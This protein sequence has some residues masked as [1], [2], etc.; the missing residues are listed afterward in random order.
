MKNNK[1]NG[2]VKNVLSYFSKSENVK[3][4]F[5][6]DDE[7]K[8]GKID[9]ED[10]KLKI[11][12]NTTNIA[13]AG[14][15]ITDEQYKTL[16]SK[17]NA[18]TSFD[19]SHSTLV[20]I[21]KLKELSYST[22]DKPAISLTFEGKDGKIKVYDESFDLTISSEY[23]GSDFEVKISKKLLSLINSEDNIVYLC[24]IEQEDGSSLQKFVFVSK[25]SSIKAYDI[26]I[27]MKE[28][29]T[30][31]LGEDSSDSGWSF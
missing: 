7:G 10:S 6:L 23:S 20:E 21:N 26:A 16:F 2:F 1:N 31:Q 28:L 25:H 30:A 19:L 14:E 8:V 17:E 5:N 22:G 11:S 9:I 15:K 12:L 27:L 3:L 4:I 18:I 13:F 24:D 29:D